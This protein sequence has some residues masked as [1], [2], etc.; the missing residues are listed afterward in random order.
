MGDRLAEFNALSVA[1][2]TELLR[3]VCASDAWLQAMT[4]GRP[5]RNADE[6]THRSDEALAVLDWSDVEQALAA[7][8]RIGERP[9]GGDREAAWSRQEQ[10][11]AAAASTNVA[12]ELRA[13]NLIYEQRFGHVF[14]ICATGRTADDILAELTQRLSNDDATERQVVRRELA[15]IVRLRLAKALQ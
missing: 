6:L 4:G 11:G 8:P 14:L 2:A 1:S 9:A 3:P 12:D 10:S 5:Y 15:A 7:H 13:G